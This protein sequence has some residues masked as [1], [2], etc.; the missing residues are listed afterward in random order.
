MFRLI[1]ATMT[2]TKLFVNT[3]GGELLCSMWTDK[4]GELN[5]RFLQ[6][7]GQKTCNTALRNEEQD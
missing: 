4:H 5:S 7:R 3:S 1:L 6:F 2:H